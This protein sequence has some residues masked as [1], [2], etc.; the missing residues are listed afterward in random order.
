MKNI[1]THTSF[2]VAALLGVSAAAI[3]QTPGIDRKGDVGYVVDSRD[4]VAKSGFGACWR[5]GFW[6]PAMVIEECDPDLVKKPEPVKTRAIEAKPEAPKP[7]PVKPAAQKVTLATDT[8]FDFDKATLRPEGKAKLDD[9]AAKIK[10]IK[11]EVI[12]TTLK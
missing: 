7:A 2:L 9:L 8:L 3:A 12:G 10:D 6:T 5:T 1:A 4:N 11:L